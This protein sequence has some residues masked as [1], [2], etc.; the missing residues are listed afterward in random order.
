MII[1]SIAI[2]IAVLVLVIEKVL[3][4]TMIIGQNLI[5][6]VAVIQDDKGNRQQLNFN[7]IDR[8]TYVGSVGSNRSQP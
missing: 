6:V 1:I 2:I 4:I 3:T 8:C 5:A 7:Y